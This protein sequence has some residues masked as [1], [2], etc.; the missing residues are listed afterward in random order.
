MNDIRKHGVHPRL[1]GPNSQPRGNAFFA[2]RRG[3]RGGRVDACVLL[4]GTRG[5][6]GPRLG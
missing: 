5:D 3:V 4:G 6:H 2:P 1:L